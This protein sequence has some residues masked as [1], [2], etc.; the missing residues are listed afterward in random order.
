MV[1]IMQINDMEISS[2]LH[3]F[4]YHDAQIHTVVGDHR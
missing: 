3:Q 4:I 1:Q 2:H